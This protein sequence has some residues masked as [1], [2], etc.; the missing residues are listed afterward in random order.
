MIKGTMCCLCNK[1]EATKYWHGGQP[2]CDECYQVWVDRDKKFRQEFRKEM[3]IE[4][5]K[6]NWFE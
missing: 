3:M 2:L 5:K 4:E 1:K 6:V